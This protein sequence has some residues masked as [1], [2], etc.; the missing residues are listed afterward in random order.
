MTVFPH[1]PAARLAALAQSRPGRLR[2]V[3]RIAARPAR[4][5][6]MPEW[7]APPVAESLRTAGI[8]RLWGHQREAADVVRSGQDVVISTGTASGKSLGYLLPLLTAVVDGAGPNEAPSWRARGVTGLYLA[9]TKALAADQLARIEAMAVPG[10]RAA[11][12]DGDTAT[13]ERRWIRQHANVVLT[14]PDLLHHSLLP[15]HRQWGPFLRALRYVVVDECHTYRGVFGSHVAL[16]LRRLRRVAARYGSD[17]VF[18]LA[19]ATVSEPQVHAGALTG[20]SAVAVTR[21]DSPRGELTFGLWQPPEADDTRRSA[22]SEAA[23]LMADL[24]D[25]DVQTLAFARSRAGVESL[26]R[27]T[28]RRLEGHTAGPAGDASTRVAAYRGG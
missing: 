8:E 16:V 28:V 18:V 17:P 15:G 13:D 11:T 24:V 6:E 12:Y 14:N 25:A 21:D 20:R 4:T 9:P 27:A 23:E 26:A 10:V 19:S 3:E 5:S 2:H 1:T 7:V 22:T